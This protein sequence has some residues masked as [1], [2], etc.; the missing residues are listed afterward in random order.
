VLGTDGL[1]LV[2]LIGLDNE[3][4]IGLGQLNRP[5]RIAVFN[6]TQDKAIELN[7]ADGDIWISNADCAE[8]FDLASPEAQPGMVMV[9]VEGGRVVPSTNAYDSKVVGVASGAGTYRPGLIL[10]RRETGLKRIAIALVGKVFCFVDAT[11]APVRVGDL[12]TSADRKGYAMRATDQQ[13]AFGA[14]LGK[15]LAPLES[16]CRLIPILV[17]LQ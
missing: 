10:D 1:P 15:A 16:G 4:Y 14:V 7:G 2:E 17:A 6:S 9:L 5:G 13:S 8:E 3:S 11:Q 12:L